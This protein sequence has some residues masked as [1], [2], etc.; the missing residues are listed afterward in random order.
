[1]E[2]ANFHIETPTAL[3]ACV[4]SDP[5]ARYEIIEMEI[6]IKASA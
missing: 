3:I 6:V 4:I 1:M 5:L 2:S